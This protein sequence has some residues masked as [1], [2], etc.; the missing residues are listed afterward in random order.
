MKIYVLVV[1]EDDFDYD[2]IDDAVVL[3]ENKEEA[4]KI[5]QEQRNVRWV[6]EKVF[7]T[8]KTTLISKYIHHG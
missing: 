6:V 3:A 4:I 7:D 5:A 8:D 2:E 1:H